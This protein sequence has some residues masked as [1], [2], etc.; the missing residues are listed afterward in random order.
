M[1]QTH[2]Q[3]INLHTVYTLAGGTSVENNFLM[4]NGNISPT[5]SLSI[6]PFFPT[7]FLKSFDSRF[8]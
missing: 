7:V 8:T 6:D 3:K 4:A 1:S 2:G 5:E